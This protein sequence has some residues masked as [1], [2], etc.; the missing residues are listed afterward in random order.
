MGNVHFKVQTNYLFRD[1][2]N[3]NQNWLELMGLRS[4]CI[5]NPFW[6][7]NVGGSIWSL[8]RSSAPL[9]NKKTISFYVNDDIVVIQIKIIIASLN[10]ASRRRSLW[11]PA[12][13]EGIKTIGRFSQDQGQKERKEKT[14]LGFNNR[15]VFKIRTFTLW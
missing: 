1:S 14:R 9:E 13:T 8:R 11:N 3:Y 6:G 4:E 15:P 2:Y 5:L 10:E 12:K 7:V